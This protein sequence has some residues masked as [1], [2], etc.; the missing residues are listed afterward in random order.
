MT[1]NDAGA[2]SPTRELPPWRHSR[3]STPIS[4]TMPAVIDLSSPPSKNSKTPYKPEG[5]REPKRPRLAKSQ[6]SDDEKRLVGDFSTPADAV[7]LPD[8]QIWM[9]STSFGQGTMNKKPGWSSSFRPVNTISDV[10]TA[11]RSNQVTY[12]RQHRPYPPPI[13]QARHAGQLAFLDR[14]KGKVSTSPVSSRERLDQPLRGVSPAK[15]RKTQHIIDLDDDDDDVGTEAP[16]SIPYTPADTSHDAPLSARS[17]QSQVS[18]GS[19][20]TLLR[21]QEQSQSKSEFRATDDLVNSRRKKTRTPGHYRRQGTQRGSPFGG[22]SV[23]GTAKIHVPQ[24]SILVHDDEGASRDQ[25]ARRL[26]LQDF[27]QGEVA[28]SSEESEW[29]Q[30]PSRKHNTKTSRHFPNARINE[31]TSE[32]ITNN[33]QATEKATDLRNQYRP[34]PSPSM[35]V[36]SSEDE[37]AMSNTNNSARNRENLPSKAKQAANSSVKRKVPRREVSKGWPL[38]FARTREYE[39]SSVMEHGRPELFLLPGPDPN[40][41]RITMYDDTDGVYDTKVQIRTRDVNVIQADDISRIR[42][43]GPRQQNGNPLI[44]DLQFAKTPD[45]QLFREE[46]APSLTTTG[47]IYTKESDAM[48][49]MFNRF[50]PRN[51]KV[52]TSEL[53]HDD[54]SEAENY[55][56]VNKMSRIPLWSQLRSSIPSSNSNAVSNENAGSTTAPSARRVST[57]PTRSTRSSAPNYD[58]EAAT[59]YREVE[60]FSVV[61]GLGTR[62]PKP[63]EYGHGRQRAVVHF[64]DLARLDEEEFMNDSLIDFYMI[65][66]FEKLHVPSQKVYFFNTYF[67]TQLTKNT[68]RQSMNYKTVERWTS[69]IDIFSYDYI[70]VP[71]NEATH[72]YLAIICNVSNIDRKPVVEDFDKD[73]AEAL[74]HSRK[75]L[76]VQTEAT[77]GTPQLVESSRHSNDA[78][79]DHN[80]RTDDEPNLFD[81]ESRLNLVDREDTG[82]DDGLQAEAKIAHVAESESDAEVVP[83]GIFSSLSAVRAKKKAKRKF[84]QAKKDPNQPIILILDSLGQVRS[85]TVRALKDWLAAEGEAKRGMEAIIKEKG[86]YPKASQIPRQDNWTDC[87]VYLLGYVEKFFQ[88]P[89]E[90]KNKLLTGEMSAHEDW[91]ELKPREMR[92][93]MRETI[94]QIA[95]EQQA[96]RKV[97]K[98]AKK[99]DSKAK[100]SPAPIKESV[101]LEASENVP[102]G[103]PE[104]GLTEPTSSETK[105]RE[106]NAQPLVKFPKPRLASP[107][108]FESQSA[109]AIARS[110]TPEA[111]VKVSD[112]PPVVTL[113]VQPA[114]TTPPSKWTPRQSPSK[115]PRRNSP[116]VRIPGKT[117]QSVESTR[118]GR[119]IMGGAAPQFGLVHPPRSASRSLSPSRRLRQDE[120]ESQLRLPVA[121]RQHTRSPQQQKGHG[122]ER[123]SPLVTGSREGS[124]GQ[125]ITIED[126][127]EVKPVAID[128]SKHQPTSSPSRRKPPTRSPRRPQVLRHSPS[129]EEILPSIPRAAQRKHDPGDQHSA[130]QKLETNASPPEVTIKET[131]KAIRSSP[132]SQKDN[133]RP[134]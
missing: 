113:S 16:P 100:A 88:D 45:F 124:E 78:E 104:V 68:G 64:D 7:A 27:I 50:L 18:V 76:V 96:A 23:S 93:A 29:H 51:D 46:H 91:P 118:S 89:D 110:Q 129:V 66:L 87:G 13:G 115:T 86:Y 33:R 131:P 127:Q 116:E 82:P 65:Y 75:D 123:S 103:R 55:K 5:P 95:E 14:T 58:L 112:S 32:Q 10:N 24:A 97:E 11:G 63:V 105:T 4:K 44:F 119:T 52:G 53:V 17:S 101:K 22:G 72:W 94:C 19:G 41:W 35:D 56:D 59:D 98:K 26:I 92:K 30:H 49:T 134:R 54:I 3:G 21:S 40:D 43:L 47:R 6:I 57:R 114:N 62:W 69:K 37:L 67:F 133:S 42:L 81:E 120:N 77:S 34:A 122:I 20:S 25:T 125:P 73:F 79:E 15:R 107:F 83:K 28:R 109:E 132:R 38:V 2:P 85:S 80:E 1:A 128:C 102:S 61:V 71:I 84:P 31:S 39:Y 121:K 9:T 111:V 8:P 70:V 90:F 36:D 74:E 130:G 12:S 126:S 117:P 108:T 60:K 99:E 48:A 106:S